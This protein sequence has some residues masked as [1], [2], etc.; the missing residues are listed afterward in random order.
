M[1]DSHRAY[2]CSLLQHP[3]S[4]ALT[5]GSGVYLAPG[6]RHLLLW[7][8]V[9]LIRVG[10][11]RT[12][13]VLVCPHAFQFMLVSSTVWVWIQ[14]SFGRPFAL[15]FPPHMF[16]HWSSSSSIKVRQQL[17]TDTS[18][19]YNYISSNPLTNHT[20]IYLYTYTICGSTSLFEPWVIDMNRW[21]LE[22]NENTALGW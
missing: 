6:W 12:D 4:T 3:P 11:R 1:W 14:F 18:T 15:S 9:Y 22:S 20:Y 16:V 13:S 19:V 7:W 10:D 21:K 17:C 5:A 2:S 8:K